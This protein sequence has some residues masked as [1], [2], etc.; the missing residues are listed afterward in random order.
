MTTRFLERMAIEIDGQG[1]PLVMIHGLGG[2]SNAFTPVIEGI[3]RVKL[4]DGS[5]PRGTV[6]GQGNYLLSYAGELADF[7]AVVLDGVAPAAGPEHSLGELRTALA[8]YR[9]AETNRWERV[10]EDAR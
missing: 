6:V 9:S 3:G 10:W 4:Y 5:E 2:T 1:E 8:M 7:A